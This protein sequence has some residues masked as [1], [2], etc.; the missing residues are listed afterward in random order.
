MVKE[1]EHFEKQECD[2]CNPYPIRWF[3]QKSEEYEKRWVSVESLLNCYR[4][5]KT[6]CASIILNFIKSEL[7]KANTEKK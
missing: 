6:E 3:S 4:E 2:Y 7:E 5:N 1:N